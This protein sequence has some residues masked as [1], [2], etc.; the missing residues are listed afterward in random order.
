M[1]KNFNMF[2]VNIETLLTRLFIRKCITYD[3]M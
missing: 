3:K 2:A 1:K